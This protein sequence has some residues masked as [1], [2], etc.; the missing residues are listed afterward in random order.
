MC[1]VSGI[2]YK[3][4]SIQGLAPVGDA[5]VTM[6]ESMTHRG[7]D[8][9]GLTVVGG[10][11]EGDLIIRIWTDD[12]ASGPEMLSR[13]EETVLEAGG[14]VRSKKSW[15]QFL[16]LDVNYEGEIPELAGALINTKGVALHSMGEA[17]EVVKDV[18]TP[19]AMDRKH[20]MSQLKGTHFLGLPLPR[21]YR[22]PQRPAN[23]LP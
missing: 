4:S 2:L 19:L 1:G 20:A 13:A 7:K 16:R 5:L 8:S 14:A 18:G 22:G 17:S 6:L 3:N 9:S 10:K 21:R 11:V 15:G 12:E 23:Q